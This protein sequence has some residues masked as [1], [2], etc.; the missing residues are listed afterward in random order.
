MT[1]VTQCS[2]TCVYDMTHVAQCSLT[3]V[4]SMTL[5]HT[6]LLDNVYNMVC[7]P[8]CSLTWNRALSSVHSWSLLDLKRRVDESQAWLLLPLISLSPTASQVSFFSRTARNLLRTTEQ[9]RSR[10]Y[11]KCLVISFNS[12][13][14][15]G[16]LLYFS[17]IFFIHLHVCVYSIIFKIYIIYYL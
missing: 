6:V 15:F 4:Y 13:A 11:F 10:F 16:T 7:V 17:I 2:L 3:C 5:C 14:S 1:C 8:Q 9:G 12:A